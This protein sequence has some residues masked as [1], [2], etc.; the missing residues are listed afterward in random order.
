MRRTLPLIVI[1]SLAVAACSGSDSAE[2][3]GDSVAA[4]VDEGDISAATG[5]DVSASE[6][7]AGATPD[8]DVP[9]LSEASADKPTDIAFPGVEVEVL[10][11]TVL[12]EGNGPLAEAGDTVIVDYIGV[13]ALDGV[14]FD[15]SYDRGAPFAVSPL[16]Q[17]QVIQG[18]ND[19]LLGA[20]A[21][22]RLQLDIP[23]DQ[24][25][26]EAARSDVIRENEPLTFVID[27]RSVIKAPDASKAPTEMGVE[28]SEGATALS[29][30]DLIE[31][32][33]AVLEKGQT[34]VFNLVLFRADNGVQIDTTWTSEPIQIQL[35]GGQFAAIV[36][37]MPGMKVGG[38]RA[39]TFPPAFGFG[40][41]GNPQVG[42]P[43]GV[44]AVLVVDLFGAY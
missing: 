2:P 27:V 20:Q 37:G 10:D 15:N 31:G 33:G 14:E 39:I 9:P 17:A 1:T 34:A 13:R 36:Q 6:A 30:E 42:L 7:T 19:G 22:A 29:F 12:T 32:D 4:V 3:A 26:G 38:R 18:W 23:S 25:Y 41:S 43:A 40:E 44:D 35:A 28:M 24:A 16:G 8:A 21:G 5:E 11:V